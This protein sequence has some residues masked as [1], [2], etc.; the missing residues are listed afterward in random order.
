MTSSDGH[1]GR[2]VGKKNRM[3]VIL[4]SGLQWNKSHIYSTS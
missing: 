1:V 4:N 2:L 3:I